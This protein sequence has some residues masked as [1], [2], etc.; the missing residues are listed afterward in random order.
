[1]ERYRAPSN[2][3]SLVIFFIQVTCK[4]VKWIVGHR[5]NEFDLVHKYFVKEL[6]QASARLPEPIPP[7]PRKT[8]GN[9]NTEQRR[10][11]L[12][13]FLNFFI[14]HKAADCQSC[15]DVLFSFLE[16]SGSLLGLTY[17]II[18]LMC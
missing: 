16:V 6:T 10:D 5:Y 1:M 7:F 4:G 8:Y 12:L 17:L 11:G 15:V 18:I 9:A 13:A 2:K 3:E 14:R